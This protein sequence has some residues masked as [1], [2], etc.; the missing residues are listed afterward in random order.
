ME[1]KK[2]IIEI[3]EMYKKFIESLS[4]LDGEKEKDREERHS[5]NIFALVTF[6]LVYCSCL[7]LNRIH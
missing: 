1:Q 7:L 3:T 6:F 4:H 2:T 5:D